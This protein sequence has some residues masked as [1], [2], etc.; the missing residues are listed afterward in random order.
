MFK[1]LAKCYEDCGKIG[2]TNCGTIGCAI[3]EESCSS[4]IINM[5]FNLIV[6]IVGAIAT[7]MTAGGSTAAVAA[8]K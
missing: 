1:D 4:T 2:M 3:D 8:A 6:G 5:A 7:V